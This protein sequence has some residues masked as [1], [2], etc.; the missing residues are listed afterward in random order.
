MLFLNTNKETLFSIW[1][2]ADDKDLQDL[3]SF[4]YLRANRKTQSLFILN[5]EGLDMMR[6]MT[7]SG[8]CSLKLMQA[9]EGN[10]VLG[11]KGYGV[12]TFETYS[13][14]VTT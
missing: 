14:Q 2:D 7:A 5:D 12:S 1:T 4:D 11:I 9:L 8:M 3:I 13:Y 6:E 10:E